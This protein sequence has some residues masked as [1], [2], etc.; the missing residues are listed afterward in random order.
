MLPAVGVVAQLSWGDG[1]YIPDKQPRCQRSLWE[2]IH[3]AGVVLVALRFPVIIANFFQ[4]LIMCC[5]ISQAGI[6]FWE[7]F[8]IY[9]FLATSFLEPFFMKSPLHFVASRCSSVCCNQRESGWST[10]SSPPSHLHIATLPPPATLCLSDSAPPFGTFMSNDPLH[11]WFRPGAPISQGKD[12]AG[13]QRDKLALGSNY[14]GLVSWLSSYGLCSLQR[15]P[16]TLRRTRHTKGSH[17][18]RGLKS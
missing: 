14:T 7:K 18:V 15:N 8:A 11:W 5:H 1:G 9:F 3:F 17:R 2:I 12:P 16:D 10:S 4:F 13:Q 6:H